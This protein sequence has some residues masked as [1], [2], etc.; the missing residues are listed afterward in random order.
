[1]KKISSEY[2]GI[3]GKVSEREYGIVNNSFGRTSGVGLGLRKLN[4]L[5]EGY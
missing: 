3:R 5:R 2:E 1:M 4:S